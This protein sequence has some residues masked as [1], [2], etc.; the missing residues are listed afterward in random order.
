MSKYVAVC[1]QDLVGKNKFPVIFEY[2]KN[3]EISSSSLS[4]LCEKEE[5]LQEIDE[6]IYDLHKIGQGGFLTINGYTVFE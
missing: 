1:V 4:Y 2:G 6:I 5:V 3:I